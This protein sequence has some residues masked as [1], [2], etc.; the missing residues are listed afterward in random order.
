MTRIHAS[1]PKFSLAVFTLSALLASS[2][3]KDKGDYPKKEDVVFQDNFDNGV[4]AIW[5]PGTSGPVTKSVA[6]GHFVLTHSGTAAAVYKTWAS[7]KVFA[8]AHSKQAIEIKQTHVKGHEYDKAGLLFS[9]ADENYILAF[10]VGDKEFRIYQKVNATNTNLVQWTVSP[11]IKG[12]LNESNKL[13]VTLAE[14]KLQY[15]IND[16]LVATME[17]GPITTLDKVGFEIVKGASAE[18]TYKVD[19]LKAIKL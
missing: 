19:Y 3:S 8:A 11:H 6:D 17:A 4:T 18:A 2:C 13:K 15:Y 12:A 10:Q 16:A 5:Q 7:T 1:F 9:V 14:G